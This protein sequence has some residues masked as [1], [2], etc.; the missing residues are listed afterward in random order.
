LILVWAAYDLGKR[1]LIPAAILS[2]LFVALQIPFMIQLA[3]DKTIPEWE[4]RTHGEDMKALAKFLLDNNLTTVATPYDIKWKLMFESRRK[5]VCAAYMFGF[6][7]ESK[8]NR[9]VIDRVNRRGMPL[10][11]VFDKEYKLAKVALRFNPR[12]AFDV[13]GFHEFLRKNRIRYQVT[14]V[15]EDYI[16][17]HGFSQHFALADPY[18]G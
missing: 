7:R 8:Y 15:G 10:A 17:Y 1:R 14:P 16:V 12:G 5:I 3:T 11:F 13:A 18:R 9:E 4:V 2:A 6:D